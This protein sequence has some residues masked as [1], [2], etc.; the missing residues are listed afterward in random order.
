GGQS[1]AALLKSIS[2]P[3]A[4]A[5]CVAMAMGCSKSGTDDLAKLKTE[6]DSLRAEVEKLKAEVHA[7]PGAGTDRDKTALPGRLAAA[8]ALTSPSQKQEAL[9]KLVVDAAELGEV[10]TAKGCLEQ[11]SS[12]SQKQDLLYKSA[13]RLAAANKVDDAVALAGTLS[14]PSQ[15]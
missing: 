10:D 14:S 6:V 1:V 5:L 3:C 2:G 4:A 13:L 8:K 11:I 12:P 15:K 9:A 7:R